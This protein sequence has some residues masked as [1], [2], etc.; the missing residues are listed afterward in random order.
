MFFDEGIKLFMND[1]TRVLI[2]NKGDRA[3]DNGHYRR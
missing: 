2:F 1:E 3:I